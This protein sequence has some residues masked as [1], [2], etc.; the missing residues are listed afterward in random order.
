MKKTIVHVASV[1]AL[2]AIT[3]VVLPREVFAK[4]GRS[5]KAAA[6]TSDQE[7]LAADYRARRAAGALADVSE[8]RSC[9]DNVRCGYWGYGGYGPGWSRGPRGWYYGRGASPGW[10]RGHWRGSDIPTSRYNRSSSR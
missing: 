8:Y 7:Q 9:R 3:T 5:A 2:V 4:D 6:S 10:S 1:C